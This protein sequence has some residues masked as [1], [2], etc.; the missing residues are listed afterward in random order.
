MINR[1]HAMINP[2]AGGFDPIKPE[3]AEKYMKQEW[4]LGIDESRL[5]QADQWINGMA[6]K[7]ILDLGAGPGHYSVAFAKRGANVTWFDVSRNYRDMAKAKAS[8]EGVQILFVLGYLDQAQKLLDMDF[9]F[10]YNNGCFNYSFD[11]FSFA[12]IVYSLVRPGGGV[13]Y[14]GTPHSGWESGKRNTW[15]RS[16]T[17]LNDRFG[18]KIGHP[19]PPPGTCGKANR[20]IANREATD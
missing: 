3:Y 10:V 17:W 4:A 18:I 16:R 5:T 20:K 1:L 19:F 2:V 15:V 7:R 12:K 6:G 8:E 11:D 14:I 13:G 9:D